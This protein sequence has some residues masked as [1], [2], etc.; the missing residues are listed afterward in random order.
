M[1]A[2]RIKIVSI[3]SVPKR[4]T[5][6]DM[7]NTGFVAS[8]AC[9]TMDDSGSWVCKDTCAKS[10]DKIMHTTRCSTHPTFRT[11]TR[12]NR[13]SLRIVRWHSNDR[14]HN[15]KRTGQ[16]QGNASARLMSTS[17]HNKSEIITRLISTGMLDR[18]SGSMVAN[19]Q[20]KANLFL[21]RNVT[22]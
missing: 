12:N 17:D 18:M 15:I 21:R 4:S 20:L 10:L 6:T 19:C 2:A 7:E 16:T 9:Q 22:P 11:M 8:A 3:S 13:S 14:T 1:L 5:W